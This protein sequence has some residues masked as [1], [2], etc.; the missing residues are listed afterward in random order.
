MTPRNT[1]H[2]KLT[3]AQVFKKFPIFLVAGDIHYGVHK[4]PPLVYPQT[5]EVCIVIS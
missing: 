1:V 5:N 4:Y 3:G 2:E